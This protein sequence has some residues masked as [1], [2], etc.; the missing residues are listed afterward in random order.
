MNDYLLDIQHLELCFQM[1]DKGLHQRQLRVIRDLS[2]H[3]AAGE[4]LAIV[5]ASGSGK[6]LLAQAVLGILPENCTSSGCICYDGSVL[7]EKR[8]SHLRGREIVFI[9]QSVN[10]LDPRMKVGRQVRG[11]YGTREQQRRVFARYGLGQEVE[12][13][14]PY[15]LSGGMARRVLVSMAVMHRAR[16]VLADEPTPGLS[17]VMA[18][19]ALMNFHEMADRDDCGVVIITHDI[20]MA[21]FV[22]DRIAVFYAGSI[23]ESAPRVDFSADGA[24]LRHPYSRALWQALPQNEFS[25]T[26]GSQPYIGSAAEGCSYAARCPHCTAECSCRQNLRV[27]RGGEVRCCHAL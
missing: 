8:L 27:L 4:V 1:Y 9:P 11:L 2:L 25:L 16:L 21:L 23:V 6:S 7:T 20:D 10:N 14:Y 26:E 18:K 24:G 17:Q 15:Q 5:G 12:E 3:V 19:E 22:A 13:M